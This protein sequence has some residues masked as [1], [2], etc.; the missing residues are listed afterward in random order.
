MFTCT[1]LTISSALE[2]SPV[3]LIPRSINGIQ[4][5]A[6]WY[7]FVLCLLKVSAFPVF[8]FVYFL[9]MSKVKTPKATSYFHFLLT[10]TVRTP[11]FYSPCVENT[12]RL[13]FAEDNYCCFLSCVNVSNKD[14]ASSF[15]VCFFYSFTKFLC[16]F[17]VLH[18]VQERQLFKLL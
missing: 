7:T 11:Y 18:C 1:T 9:E 6:G 10:S 16:V 13:V 17:S 4:C 8:S 15:P 12:V 3:L 2:R 14:L 5:E